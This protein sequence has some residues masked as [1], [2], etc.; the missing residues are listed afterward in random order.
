MQGT[1]LPVLGVLLLSA[2]AATAD[3]S[4]VVDAKF[5][6]FV[7]DPEESARFYQLLGFEVAHR[8]EGGYTTL[9]TGRVVVAL[10]PVPS[11]LPL[12]WVGFLR[13]P[14]IGTEIVFYT[15]RLEELRAELEGAGHEPGDV[16]RQPWGDLDFRVRDPD[17]YYV[18][19]SE[20]TAL[21]R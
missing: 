3:P 19:V 11:W 7:T 5:E 13:H 2:P 10:S 1:L 15:R 14:P 18:R 8:K 4:S 17:G 12:R 16:V 21:P 9:R 20:G 6:L